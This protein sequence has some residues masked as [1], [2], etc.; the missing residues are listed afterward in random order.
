MAYPLK[1]GLLAFM[2]PSAN[3]LAITIQFNPFMA[4]NPADE[5]CY[6]QAHDNLLS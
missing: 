1:K 6:F 3:Y 2:A 5:L 4:D